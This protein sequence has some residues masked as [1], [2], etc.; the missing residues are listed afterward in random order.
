MIVYL[1]QSYINSFGLLS[2]DLKDQLQ[3][4]HITST[5]KAVLFLDSVIEPSVISG[6][7][8]AFDRL[9]IAME[10]CGDESVKELAKLIRIPYGH[11][12]VRIVSL[13]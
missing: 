11:H 1:Y 4:E 5:V 6:I 13:I 7:S 9:L 2:D 10:N 3:V 12:M 8:N